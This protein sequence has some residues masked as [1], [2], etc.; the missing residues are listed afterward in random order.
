MKFNERHPSKYVQAADLK[1]GGVTVVLDRVAMEP[2]GQDKKVKP[3]LYF[4][5]A[6]KA[7]VLNSTNDEEIGKLFGDDDREWRGE[8]IV[9]Y[10]TTTTFGGKTVPCIRV[11]P[12]DGDRTY[13]P[14]KPAPAKARAKAK[15]APEAE[16]PPVNEDG[17]PG[18][19]PDVDRDW[20]DEIPF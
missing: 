1:P 8:K 3:V 13:E 10:P 12:V 2:V 7:M 4:Q 15:P 9:L 17:D 16:E 6:S 19:Q 14:P 11:R 5:N 18:P 20:N